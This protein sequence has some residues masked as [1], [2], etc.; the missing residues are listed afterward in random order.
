MYLET[1]AAGVT[2]QVIFPPWGTV[3]YHFASW[4]DSG[5]WRALN[6]YLRRRL[7]RRLKRQADP[8]AGVVDSQSVKG[9]V[10]QDNG[11]DGGKKVNGRKRHVL[12]DTLGLL[13]VVLVTPAN[14][15]DQRG[16][17]MLLQHA[18]YES[19]RL[20]HLWADQG[21]RGAS[22]MEA[23]LVTFGVVLEIVG[24]VGKRQGFQLQARRWVVERSLAWYGNYRRLAKDY[25]VL[26]TTSEAFIYMASC[27]LM[28][29]RLAGT[30]GPAWRCR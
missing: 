19:T 12:V 18:Q 29:K 13:L 27:D 21:Y 28:L 24:Q 8:S 1:A 10:H 17:R 30:A 6:K 5:L 7:R 25:E 15:S 22:L 9:G 2:C 4:R 20:R 16:V 11:Y 14:T 3:Y 26:T 23:L